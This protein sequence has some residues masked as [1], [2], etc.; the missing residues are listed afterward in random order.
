MFATNAAGHHE[1]FWGK[2]ASLFLME[3][4][5]RYPMPAGSDVSNLLKALKGV[6]GIA[7]NTNPETTVTEGQG[8]AMFSA[9]MRKD[10]ETLKSLVVAWQA[11]GQGIPKQDVSRPCGGC[12][13]SGGGWQEPR[14]ICSAS[15]S[16]CLCRS[17]SGA[18]MPGWLMPVRDMGSLGSATDGDEDGITGIIY[19]AE[20]MNSSEV[21]EYAVKSIVAFVNE[22]LGLANPSLNSRTVPVTGEIPKELQV[23]YLWRGGTCW[24]GYDKSSDSEDRNLCIAPAYFSPGQWRLFRDYVI[25]YAHLVPSPHD[26]VQVARV[27]Q[28]AI[29][30]G[31]NTLQRISCPNGL[32]SNWWSIPD[33]GWPWQGSL[34]C[35]NS[36][37]AAGAYGADA[38]RMPWRVV[39]DY[40]WYPEET[41][42]TP[43]FDEA[44][45]RIGTWGAKQY[46]NRWQREW[47]SS[48]HAQR[49][50]RTHDRP[51]EGGFPPLK[52]GVP[53]L[54]IDQVLQPLQG[55]A[56][57][58]TV[59]L[60]FTA[61]AWNG[62]GGYPVVTTF[63]TP[64]DELTPEMRQE[65]LDFLCDIIFPG[66]PTYAYY[67]L[68]QEV[69]CLA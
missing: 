9:G 19:L 51:H 10:V 47:I 32:V 69:R 50:P 31:Y 56:G 22:D 63:Q 48:I 17:V 41:Q 25:E 12:G 68:G 35:K 33:S 65:W 21:R 24:G 13:A 62:W 27:L 59:P 1:K 11:M 46:A 14:D 53:P 64:S 60:G 38:A 58:K 44:G 54:R 5:Q 43:L 4:E 57:C 66:M 2:L 30:W 37:T 23:M 45:Q 67:D 16:P 6:K 34:K 36:G 26:S 40:L 20:L 3:G 52:K 42:Q 18:Y 61:T 49:D 15:E 28:S 8:Y 29:T 7:L 55:F 39:L